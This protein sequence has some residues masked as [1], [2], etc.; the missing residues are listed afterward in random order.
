VRPKRAAD[1]YDHLAIGIVDFQRRLWPELDLAEVIA[2]GG[3]SD[4][5]LGA[6]I[7]SLIGAGHNSR[8]SIRADAEFRGGA[9][10]GCIDGEGTS[11]SGRRG[12]M[13]SLIDDGARTQLNWASTLDKA[14]DVHSRTY[15]VS[16]ILRS[17]HD[18]LVDEQV[19]STNEM[20]RDTR[21]LD[22]DAS[23]P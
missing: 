22:D 12:R 16:E 6:S 23:L 5:A 11:G 3:E 8:R 9:G 19:V 13:D 21:D 20:N 14:G 1:E 7:E 2:A 4:G 17:P 18:A 15:E 10:K